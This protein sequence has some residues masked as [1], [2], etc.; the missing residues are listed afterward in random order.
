MRQ[1]TVGLCQMNTKNDVEDS[2]RQIEEMSAFC[3]S[4]GAQLVVFPEYSTYLADDGIIE[5]GE[6]LDG[7]IITRFR[8]IARKNKLFVHNGSFIEKDKSE[9]KVFNTSV[10]IDPNGEIRAT[11]RKIHLFD[12]VIPGTVDIRESETIK[13]GNN[14]VTLENEIG[15]F[16]FSICYDLRFPELYRKLTDLGA[17]VIFLPS[18]FTLYTGKDHWEPLLRARAIENQVYLIAVDQFGAY[19]EGHFSYGN[20]MIVDPWGTVVARAREEVGCTIYKLD[21]DAV[22]RVR[23]KIPCLNHRVN[24]DKVD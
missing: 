22:D 13:R 3:S 17:T 8:E 11:Y 7:P 24:L 19:A 5:A 20:S 1:I 14:I 4:E 18:A 12:V 10:F 16:G 21:L 6:F 9:S 15:N 23:E 2:F